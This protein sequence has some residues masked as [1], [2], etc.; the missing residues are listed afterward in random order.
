MEAETE[1][2]MDHDEETYNRETGGYGDLYADDED[3]VH[4]AGFPG[5]TERL[6][7]AEN[8]SAGNWEKTTGKDEYGR[9]KD[10]DNVNY[11]T[12]LKAVAF[13]CGNQP[14][15]ND[16][17]LPS[18]LEKVAKKMKKDP[19]AYRELVVTNY[20]DIAKQDETMKM[21]PVKDKNHTDEDNAMEKVKG[22]ETPKATPS[23]TKEN[24]KGKP[25]GVKEMGITPKKGIT[26]VMD[27]P[28]K[29][30]VIDQLK[31]TL[32]RMMREDVHYKYSPGMSVKTPKGEGQV[33]E[34][35]GGTITVEL[36]NGVNEDFQV[37]TLDHFEKKAKEEEMNENSMS[38][39]DLG[40]SF[41]KLKGDMSR[42]DNQ[43]NIEDQLIT[44]LKSHDWY[45]QMS[46]DPRWWE[47]GSNE[48]DEISALMS[49]L[50]RERAKELHDMYS[51]YNK[52][53]NQ[54]MKEVK[55][56]KYAKLKEYLRKAMK[57][58]KEV[59]VPKGANDATKIAAAQKAGMKTDPGSAI[60]VIE[61]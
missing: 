15:M 12:F 5:M 20:A 9:F 34:I 54:G 44:A 43:K 26:S 41:E 37:N 24:R 50:P 55:K 18:I 61:K 3:D 28:G 38:G 40:G 19:N 16:K 57:E 56:D 6:N 10:V 13:E 8:K 39:V 58:K 42:E 60:D 29:E 35:K 17:L 53:K 2:Q 31:E 32:I 22:Q 1:K 4:P 33:K 48:A 51:P 46:D 47:K 30:K 23:S 49:Q 21:V 59:I 27:M 11:T 25:A 7:E 52:Q 45:Y 36:K 14:D